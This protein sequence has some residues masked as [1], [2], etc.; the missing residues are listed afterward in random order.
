MYSSITLLNQSLFNGKLTKCSKFRCFSVHLVD[1]EY[2]T[3]INLDRLTVIVYQKANAIPMV[4]MQKFVGLVKASCPKALQREVEL[5]NLIDRCDEEIQ[6]DLW[7]RFHSPR[8][9]TSLSYFPFT[10]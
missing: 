6:S 10:I 8:K 1:I 3:L 4:H 9:H 5:V 2:L 7:E